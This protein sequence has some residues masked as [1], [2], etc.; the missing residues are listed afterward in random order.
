MIRRG[1]DPQAAAALVNKAQ[2]DYTML[3]N[4]ERE[5]M[6]RM[7]PFYS[8]TRGVTPFV[9]G[10]LMER[11][12][13]AMGRQIIATTR[14]GQTDEQGVTPD[15]I[16]ETA[17]IP[18]GVSEDG[19]RSY[20]TGFGMPYEDPL[21]FAQIARGNVSGLLRELGSRLNPVPK[22][23]IETATGRSLYQAG[24]FG[25]RE[26][27]DLDPTIGRIR[28]NISD[29]MTGEKTER[30]QPFL[31]NPWLEYAIANSGLGRTLNTI[32]TATDPR[33]YDT[34]PWKL[35][36]NLGTGVRVADVSPSAQDAI[37]RE[38]LARVMKDFGGR[39]YTRPYFPDYAQESWT[40]EQAADAAK[41]EG[42]M[43][44]LNQRAT[45]RK[46]MEAAQ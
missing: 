41:I 11:P 39:M 42:I 46:R 4:F 24:P 22:S 23:V 3:S 29:L 15:Y 16:R 44:L 26:I 21:Q 13:G 32:R 34:I 12:A 2:V 17:S 20:I 28:A 40:P 36:L 33:K 30:A 27:E 31:N 14:A 8:Y 1:Y 25:G 37:L 45:D 35:L 19:T 5:Y 10:Q 18:L 9:Y 6:R 43:K 7:F 38:R